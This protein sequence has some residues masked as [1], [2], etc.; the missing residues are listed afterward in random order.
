[1]HIF[2]ETGSE[3]FFTQKTDSRNEIAVGFAFLYSGWKKWFRFL[4]QRG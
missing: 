1:M 4:Q 2:A 3:Q